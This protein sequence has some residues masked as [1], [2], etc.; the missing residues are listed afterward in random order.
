VEGAA[1]G[2]S[3]FFSV[4]RT[5]LETFTRGPLTLGPSP[6]QRW[7]RLTEGLGGKVEI[8][9]KREDLNSGLACGGNK[10]RKLE[11]LAAEALELGCDTLLS[12]GR[13]QSNHTRQVAAVSAKLGLK[14]VLV[15][16]RWVE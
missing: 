3:G 6:L 8:W 2:C 5:K 12:I 1:L 4:S 10:T 9:A 15:Q 7:N 11:Y 13:I 14:S 16:H